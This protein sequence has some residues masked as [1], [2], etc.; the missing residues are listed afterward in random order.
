MWG[1]YK[2]LLVTGYDAACC[3]RF[4]DVSV[5]PAASVC[6]ILWPVD[7]GSVFSETSIYCIALYPEAGNSDDRRF[8]NIIAQLM[9]SVAGDIPCV[10]YK[11]H[12]IPHAVSYF[13]VPLC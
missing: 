10:I 1:D 3:D 12:V 11:V 5:E 6:K 8:D 4:A 13:L 2:V 9:V 7:G